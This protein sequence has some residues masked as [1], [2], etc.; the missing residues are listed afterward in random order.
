[1]PARKSALLL[2]ATALSASLALSAGPAAAYLMIVRQGQE[3][4]DLPQTGDRLGTTVATGD[5]N[6][7][8]YDDLASAAPYEN[9]D[10]GPPESHGS[11]II[12]YGSARG[13]THVSADYLTVGAV[14]DDDVRYGYA[15]AVGDFNGDG[16]DDLAVGLPDMDGVL[17]TIAEAG[18]VWIHHGGPGGLQSLPNL[19]LDHADAGD[20][21]E[22][23]DRFGFSL[24]A[25]DFDGDLK[26]DLAVGVIG[27]DSGS[28]AVAVFRG[29]PAGITTIGATTIR[30]V[31]I[32]STPEPGGQFGFALAAGTLFDTVHE[33][34][35]IGAPFRMASGFA[36]SG[37]VFVIKGSA[38]GLSLPGT[39]IYSIPA[40]G[41]TGE[42][43]ARFGQ[44]L[45]IGMISEAQG[46]PQLVVG[47]P[48][49]DSFGAIDAGEAFV[50]SDFIPPFTPAGVDH[51]LQDFGGTE[52]G[53]N[54]DQFGY[55][56]AVGDFDQDGRDDVAVGCPFED[57]ENNPVSGFNTT[58]PGQVILYLGSSIFPQPGTLIHARTLNDTIQ[59]QANLGT[60]LAFGRFDDSGRANL[61]IGCPGMDDRNYRTG[62][63]IANSGQVYVYAP[64]RQIKSRPNRGS[65]AL[66][67]NG[68]IIYAQRPFQAMPPASIT[69]AMTVLLAVEAIQHGDIDSNAVYDVPEWVEDNVSG[70]QAG[71]VE[72]QQ[73]RFVDLIKLAVAVSAGDACYSIGDMLTGSDAVWNGLEGTIPEFADMMNER[74]QEIGML[75][76]NFTNPSG[77]PLVNHFTTPYD[78]AL[79]S[80]EAMNNPL[81]RYFVGTLVWADIPNWPV[82]GYG[83]MQTMQGK[84][85]E[86][87][88][89]KPG[90]NALSLQT[91]L[92]HATDTDGTGGSV[93]ASAFGIPST[94]Y[95]SPSTDS[96]ENTGRDL[97]ALAATECPPGFAA[98][99]PG[100]PD[101][102]PWGKRAGVP[103]GPGPDQCFQVF[104]D[105]RSED[106]VVIEAYPQV[107]PGSAAQFRLTTSRRSEMYIDPGD[108]VLVTFEHGDAHQG[109]VIGNLW[110]TTA[111]LVITLSEPPSTINL[112][113]AP[114]ATHTIAADASISSLFQIEIGNASSSLPI[115]LSFEEKGYQSI[116]A[117]GGRTFARTTLSRSHELYDEVMMCCVSGLDLTAG[118]EIYFVARPGNGI[119]AA[120]P[121]PGGIVE[122][123]VSLSP[124]RPN[125]FTEATRFAFAL[126]QAG[127]V[128]LSVH[129]V[130]GRRLRSIA[131][132]ESFAAGPHERLWDGLDDAG[133]K[134]A[135]GVY[136]VRLRTPTTTRTER[137]ILL[138]D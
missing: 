103:T 39:L 58:S 75:Q 108:E 31:Q 124:A 66:D 30:P 115:W 16:Y 121:P 10:I 132:G 89:V 36:T 48:G 40:L 111:N 98:P 38:T 1:M 125:P 77:R 97:M 34:L 71:L 79:L 27:E 52:T 104:L 72:N 110:P 65:L 126:T 73:I 94:S 8:G 70:S 80:R 105:E 137:A 119:V 25:G 9:E 100:P 68:Q 84:Y 55:A 90:N 134:A 2:A 47:A 20:A 109:F 130:A 28:G 37:M 128:W 62:A 92:W 54:T 53:E 91:G 78:F 44:A 33:D 86:C 101:P 17:F 113:L 63:M 50:I 5:F 22:A 32:G 131:G 14:I 24:A 45:A 7:D 46:T 60:S 43:G 13:I 106:D 120:D 19:V 35:A 49:H 87:D 83:W 74:A 118:N 69:K 88:G 64:W 102:E 117:I 59:T 3:S 82:T 6:N 41:F 116:E 76:T 138:D 51:M 15:L 57:L 99:Q 29:S 23:N 21:I 135:P 85:P 133:R 127:P 81:Y 4:A 114:G 61:A 42:A 129:D 123:G 67:C 93:A 11:V 95:G 96:R 18:E 56:L 112:A 107:V 12:N 136:F 26:D 122:G